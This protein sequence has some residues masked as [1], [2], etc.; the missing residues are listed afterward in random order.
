[1][2]IK[3]EIVSLKRSILQGSEGREKTQAK[4]KQKYDLSIWVSKKYAWNFLFESVVELRR[5]KPNKKSQ[6]EKYAGSHTYMD[7]KIET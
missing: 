5:L 7:I 3:R 6:S 2:A 4:G 1:M